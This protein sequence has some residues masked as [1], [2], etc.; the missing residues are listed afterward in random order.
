[1]FKLGEYFRRRYDAL[2]NDKY[3]RP[4]KIYVLSSDRDRTIMSAQATLAALFKVHPH[5]ADNPWKSIGQLV[6]Y[7]VHTVSDMCTFVFFN[8]LIWFAFLFISNTGAQSFRYVIRWWESV[9]KIRCYVGKLFDSF[10]N[11]TENFVREQDCTGVLVENER[12]KYNEC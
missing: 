7:P 6:T 9:P 12:R 5:H 8:F 11:N 2:L 1:M 10:D 3:Y 4:N